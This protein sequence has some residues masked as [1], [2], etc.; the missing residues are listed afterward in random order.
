[1]YDERHFSLLSEARSDPKTL[2]FLDPITLN[3]MNDPVMAADG[4][5]YD[6]ECILAWFDFCKSR[7]SPITSPLTGLPLAHED[8]EPNF[9]LRKQL[10]VFKMS[11]VSTIQLSDIQFTLSSE[12]YKELDKL[13]KLPLMEQLNLKMPKLIVIG[14]ESHGKSTLL[15]RIIGLPLFPKDKRICTRCVIRV[16]LR[17]CAPDVPSIA[18]ITVKYTGVGMKPGGVGYTHNHYGEDSE[19]VTV[20]PKPVFLSHPESV[21]IN[22]SPETQDYIDTRSTN[23]AKVFT[24]PEPM[25]HDKSKPPRYPTTIAA[26]D[27]IREKIQFVMDELVRNDPQKRMVIDDHEIVVRINLPY[28]LN[29]DIL[30]LPGLVTTSPEGVTQNLPEVTQNLALRIVKEELNSSIFLLVNDVRVPPNQSRACQVIQQAKAENQTMGIFTKLDIYVSEDGEEEKDLTNLL[31]GHTNT[32]FRV[33][34]GWMASA[35]RNEQHQSIHP[36]PYSSHL[37]V[38]AP[39]NLAESSELSAIYQMTQRESDLVHS[40][41]STLPPDCMAVVGIDHIRQRLQTLYDAFI[42][43][44]WI[45]VLMAKMENFKDRLEIDMN[46]LGVPLPPDP[47]YHAYVLTLKDNGLDFGYFDSSYVRELLAVGFKRLGREADDIWIRFATDGLFWEMIHYWHRTFNVGREDDVAFVPYLNYQKGSTSVPYFAENASKSYTRKYKPFSVP[48]ITRTLKEEEG[49]RVVLHELERIVDAVDVHRARE[50]IES[51]LRQSLTEIACLLQA[52]LEPSHHNIKRIV[53]ALCKYTNPEPKRPDDSYHHFKLQRF[54]KITTALER[55]VSNRLTQATE[56]FMAYYERFNKVHFSSPLLFSEYFQEKNTK[57]G[58][59]E[60]SCCLHWVNPDMYQRAPHMLIDKFYETVN[61]YL[62]DFTN[63]T[64]DLTNEDL[65]DLVED[66]Q[67]K[68]LQLLRNL[69]DV[70]IVEK[71]MA[72]F[73]EHVME[74]LPTEHQIPGVIHGKPIPNTGV[75]LKT[76][77]HRP[78]MMLSSIPENF[79]SR[80]SSRKV[81]GGGIGKAALPAGAVKVLPTSSKKPLNTKVKSMFLNDSESDVVEG[82]GANENLNPNANIRRPPSREHS[83]KKKTVKRVNNENTANNHTIFGTNENNK[84]KT[85]DKFRELFSKKS[86]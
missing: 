61:T 5:T 26:L 60:I 25:I 19:K 68:R 57:T 83:S 79:S 10:E 11:K 9:E 86:T 24:N 38:T 56:H 51:M 44:H 41:F 53:K 63:F 18:E 62:S 16:H 70:V 30:D 39:A 59:V 32:A 66:C 76:E 20:P 4:N 31:Q 14:N 52:K 72:V 54:P 81:G 65:N 6:R 7:K 47:S 80:G 22:R 49:N 23:E 64:A 43:N 48:L 3:L 27:N 15:E 67:E 37:P 75:S 84:P 40:K 50:T 33:G 78:G 21:E 82:V 2:R 35:S 13:A 69:A 55:I 8:L 17:R 12:I 71:E 29:I 36:H 73:S 34:Y 28:C 77:T 1:M 46:V 74:R 85:L 42:K 58:S 45:P